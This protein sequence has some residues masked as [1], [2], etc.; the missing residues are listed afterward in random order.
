MSSA[1]SHTESRS[2][3]I[4][5]HR[6][7]VLSCPSGDSVSVAVVPSS[8]ALG[9]SETADALAAMRLSTDAIEAGLRFSL[10][11]VIEAYLEQWR[12]SPSYMAL[13]SWRF[14][15]EWTS[16]TVSSFVPVLSTDE[17]ELVEILW[18]SFP[19]QRG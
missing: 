12:I 4:L 5:T 13:N 1:S 10:H 16:R 8:N 19:F 17:I 15:T 9:D 14:Q 18:G 11:P 6:S 2:V 7:R 3:E